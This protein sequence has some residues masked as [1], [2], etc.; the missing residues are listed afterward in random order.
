[1]KTEKVDLYEVLNTGIEYDQNPNKN[2]RRH[3]L[4]DDQQAYVGLK[5]AADEYGVSVE[6]LLVLLNKLGYIELEN[7]DVAQETARTYFDS[8]AQ[9]RKKLRFVE[10]CY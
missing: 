7:A 9:I 1:M 2:S 8:I 3:T 4:P 6:Q 5:F 10:I